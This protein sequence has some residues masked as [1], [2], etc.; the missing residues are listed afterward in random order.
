MFF[1]NS[2]AFLI[3]QWMLAIWSLVVLPFLNPACLFKPSPLQTPGSHW[4]YYCL[5]SFACSRIS[6]NQ[7]ETVY[8]LSR[9]TFSKQCGNIFSICL[10]IYF[11]LFLSNIPFCECS[12]IK[13]NDSSSILFLNRFSLYT[14]TMVC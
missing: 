1:W 10:S 13:W 12:F 5:H 11:S 2:L 9:L 3:I 8:N 6:Y 7:E 4:L 14:C